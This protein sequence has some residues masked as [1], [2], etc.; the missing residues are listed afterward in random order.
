[1]SGEIGGGVLALLREN[2]VITLFLAI[3][4]GYL[5]GR[6]KLGTIAL[7]PVA[8]ALLVSLVLGRFGFRITEAAQ[9]VGFAL[10]IFAVG[11][12]AGPRFFEVL[13][14]QGLR[15]L[16]LA[17]FVA[18]VGIAVALAAGTLAD[19]PYGGTAGLLAGALTTTP[20]LAAAQEA[21]R[22][23][24]AHL[25]DGVAP[26][27][28]LDVIATSYAITYIVGLL[29]IIAA[30]R[31]LPRVLQI[32]LAAEARAHE[33]NDAPQQ[34]I[35]LQ[36]RGYRVTDLDLMRLTVREIRS[37]YWDGFA[38]V[39][40]RRGGEWTTLADDDHLQF[41]DEIFAYGDASFFQRGIESFGDEIP[42]TSEIEIATTQAQ[43]VIARKEA[44]GKTL[45]ELGLARR[46]GLVVTEVRRDGHRLPLVSR[47]RLQRGDVLHV[48][49]PTADVDPLREMLGPVET[50][51]VETDMTTFAWGIAAG[52]ALGLLSVN[53]GGVP[54]GLGMAG[55]LLVAGILIG[56]LNATRPTVGKF[57]DSA[58][59]VLME[60]GLI[61]FIVGVGLQAGGGIVETFRDAGVELLLAA[62]IT[63]TAPV[64]L[65]YLFGRK[66]LKLPPL[67]LMGALTG[68]M[69]SA[70]ALSLVNSE[71]KSAVPSLGYTGTY[72][73]ANVFLTLAGT[74]VMLL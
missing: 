64:L 50:D 8:G 19:L 61:I 74:A 21:V 17:V 36:A 2:P 73:F 67:V 14:N 69:T 27:A 29:G 44:V 15:Y 72:A 43:V 24:I 31:L 34:P 13:K 35:Q 12:N 63:V 26:E 32:D 54:L 28:V 11:Y 57:P 49:G 33:A 51:V 3:G 59:W 62:V 52:A 66:I 23:G 25:P 4:A 47:L 7:G 71:A 16:A 55:G 46:H 45:A 58:R 41:G 38:V 30:I 68:A 20:T 37:R 70:A 9:S 53:V 60:F 40:L 65:G 22:A 5:V 1:M 18:V 39:R 6:I 48:V 42:A 56:W 10:F